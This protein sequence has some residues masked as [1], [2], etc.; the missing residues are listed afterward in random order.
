[1]AETRRRSAWIR[2][3]AAGLFAA[4]Y[5]VALATF[6]I[7]GIVAYAVHADG[8][9]RLAGIAYFPI[10]LLPFVGHGDLGG[11]PIHGEIWLWWFGLQMVLGASAIWLYPYEPARRH[12]PHRPR[13][14]APRSSLSGTPV[15]RM[16]RA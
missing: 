3:R 6:W 7:A 5:A 4:G 13:V 16:P 1:M 11:V 2:S 12:R 9:A 14:T 15:A 10:L 8:L